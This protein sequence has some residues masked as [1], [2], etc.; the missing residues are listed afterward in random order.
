M[1]DG[2]GTGTGELRDK[3]L[4]PDK[5]TVFRRF[6][7]MP[8]T[9]YYI[10]DFGN[11]W[12]HYLSGHSPYVG[13]T[14]MGS[15]GKIAA[16]TEEYGDRAVE[17]LWGK[18]FWEPCLTAT[19]HG[20]VS[21]GPGEHEAFCVNVQ[22]RN[23][24]E[25]EVPGPSCQCGFWAYYTP[26]STKIGS[27]VEWTA[28]AAVQVWGD[29]VLG[30]KGVRAQK[31]QI[32]GLMPPQEVVFHED[33][34]I[35]Q[36]WNDLVMKLGVP[37]FWSKAELLEFF[38]PQDVSELLPKPEPAPA[39]PYPADQLSPYAYPRRWQMWA[40]QSQMYW[41]SNN[42]SGLTQFSPPSNPVAYTPSLPVVDAPV[43]AEVCCVCSYR[44]E[45]VDKKTA[46]RMLA[47][48]IMDKHHTGTMWVT[49][50]P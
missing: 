50:S 44:I 5:L 20:H 26:E 1:V 32:V 31:M 11:E 12:G 46:E 2:F 13:V 21:Y 29:V 18:S 19:S 39:F 23:S 7:F 17:I 25:H 36:A 42:T 30:E 49:T 48:H 8:R 40:N 28:L 9:G 22:F 35:V 38:P 37:Q 4:I 47:E 3:K 10:S 27:T 24:K 34:R 33:V 6:R 43:Y 15:Y 45:A 16:L 14:S 41:V